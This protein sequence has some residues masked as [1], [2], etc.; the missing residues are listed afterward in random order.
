MRRVGRARCGEATSTVATA[1]ASRTMGKRGAPVRSKVTRKASQSPVSC[2]RNAMRRP[3]TH[4]DAPATARS[5]ARRHRRRRSTV[6]TSRPTAHNAASWYRIRNRVR[7]PC[8]IESKRRTTAS[9]VAVG[10]CACT[11]NGTRSRAATTV[12]AAS[13]GR[14]RDVPSVRSRVATSRRSVSNDRTVPITH[15][16]T[17]AASSR[18]SRTMVA[19]AR[20]VT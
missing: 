7:A 8:G 5:R 6:T 4:A 14:R 13:P 20:V 19:R 3:S 10:W 11:I 2:T 16:A 18:R 12:R 17:R 1:T 9:S 15:P